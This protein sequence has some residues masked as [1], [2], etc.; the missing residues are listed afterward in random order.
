M[1]TRQS[2]LL[3]VTILLSLAPFLL[4]IVVGRFLLTR[5]WEG[6]IEMLSL[7]L[8]MTL[9]ELGV[10]IAARRAAEGDRSL[11]VWFWQ[12]NAVIECLFPTLAI[13]LL[14]SSGVIPPHRGIILPWVISYSI[15]RVL[16]ILSLSPSIGIGIESVIW[17]IS[18][19]GVFAALS[20][21]AFYFCRPR[22]IIAYA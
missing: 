11:P 7:V 2:Q 19:A 8:A 21:Q 22:T 13:M 4:P 3:C 9:Y 16:S 1:A 12:L 20:P 5:Q 10:L 6:F 14:S 18:G 17:F 15:F